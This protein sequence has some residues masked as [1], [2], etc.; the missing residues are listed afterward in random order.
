MGARWFFCFGIVLSKMLG[1]TSASDHKFTL[2]SETTPTKN[3]TKYMKPQFSR[4][5]MSGNE[6]TFEGQEVSLQPV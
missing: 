6:E 4:P 3:Q 2:W 1:G 5:W